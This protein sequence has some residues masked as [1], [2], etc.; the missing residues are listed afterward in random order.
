MSARKEKRLQFKGCGACLAALLSQ[1]GFELLNALLVP[2]AVTCLDAG[3][4]EYE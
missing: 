1:H 2:C 3:A 4:V